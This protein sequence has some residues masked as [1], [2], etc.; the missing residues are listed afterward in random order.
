M[1]Q[2]RKPAIERL[3]QRVESRVEEWRNQGR[4][5]FESV[6]AGRDALFEEA[7]ERERRLAEAIDQEEETSAR[8]DTQRYEFAF[9]VH[10]GE[11]GKVLRSL[12]AE[13]ARL[14]D[15]V[16]G[17]AGAVADSGL[18]GS[19]LVIDPSGQKDSEEG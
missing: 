12:S 15:V 10:S 8:E 9:V 6:E 7:A 19:W 13:G 3:L 5:R 17:R 11:A 18:E 14:V 4:A 16:P 1:G 2:Q